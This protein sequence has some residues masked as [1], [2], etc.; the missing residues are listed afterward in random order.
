ME[1][2]NFKIDLQEN[3]VV[4]DD[5]KEGVVQFTKP[6][7]ITDGSTQ[8]NGTRYDIASMDTSLYNGIVNSSHGFDITDIIGNVIGLAKNRS[9]VTISGISFAVKESALARFSHDMLL[10]GFIKAF[11]IETLGEPPD[12]DGVFFDASLVGLALVIMGNNKSAQVNQIALNSIE[13]SKK[14]G[15]DTSE[16]E[17][18]YKTLDKINSIA[19]NKDMEFVTV[20]NTK[21]HEVSVKYKNAAGNEVEKKLSSKETLDISKDQKEEVEKQIQDAKAP[22]PQKVTPTPTPAVP[23]LNIPGTD[24][25]DQVNKALEPFMAKI[26]QLEQSLFDKTGKE[27]TFT[28]QTDTRPNQN[29]FTQEMEKMGWK[30]RHGAQINYAWD[31]LNGKD[32]S[33]G[34]KL[35]E[36]NKY[37]VE[38]LKKA[39]I[40][41]NS[42]TIADFGN[43]VISPELLKDIEGHR[44]NFQP[45][46]SKLEFKETLSLQ[47]AWLKRSGD[48][49]MAEVETCDDDANGELKPISEYTAPIQQANLH[50][51]AAVTP[52]CNAATRFLA[53]DLLGDV[54]AGYRNDY[55]RKR[56]QLFIVRCQQAINSTGN[57]IVYDTT[58]D[59]AS[60]K[61]WISSWIEAQEEIMG[62]VFIFNQKTY[63]ELLQRAIGA[64]I[65]GPL[66][67][68]F[69]TGDQ[70]LIA[71]SPYIVVPNELLP[72]LNTAETKSFT[73]EGSAV[74]ITEA[75][76]YVELSTFSGRVSGGLQFDLSTEAAYEDSGTVKSAFQR[77][78]LVLRGS[79]FRNGAI[80][81]EDKV[82]SLGAPGVS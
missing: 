79:F 9:K 63:G 59:A 20:Q 67:G 57:S 13:Q 33:A 82:A 10:A 39:D 2:N 73:V 66:A 32:A 78:E 42:I 16:I 70:P 49:D 43:F 48:I 14:D 11:S 36:I 27:P 31:F 55:D 75:A 71:G 61:S 68:L 26:G 64:G 54:A 35:A 3:K 40:I 1:K 52:V 41:E 77:N 15:L 45:L 29:P 51:L 65:S 46:I 47:M 38:E 44:S 19:D 24:V 76:F 22:E 74:S 5:N 17:E 80:R 60:L 58:S 25:A 56:A 50:E 6:V 28:K 23:A 72:T 30:A 53:A 62:G 7:T 8:L 12:E 18:K 37:N 21:D 34:E 81:D 69:T 4:K